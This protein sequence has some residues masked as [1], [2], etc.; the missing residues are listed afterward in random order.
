MAVPSGQQQQVVDANRTKRTRANHEPG[1]YD[2]PSFYSSDY[3][4]RTEIPIETGADPSGRT[5]DA[6]FSTTT[7]DGPSKED[8]ESGGRQATD[9]SNNAGLYR[10]KCVSFLALVAGLAAF[11]CSLAALAGTTNWVDTWEPIDLPPTQDWPL[12]FGTGYGSLI[13]SRSKTST[14]S[15]SSSSLTTKATASGFATSR[16]DLAAA[17]SNWERLPIHAMENVT[18][19]PSLSAGTSRPTTTVAPT[20]PPP[21]EEDDEFDYDDDD[22][23]YAQDEGRQPMDDQVVMLRHEEQDEDD[24]QVGADGQQQMR[25]TLIVVFHVGLFRACPVLKGELPSSVVL[26]NLPCAP[27]EYTNWRPLTG[28]SFRLWRNVEYTPDFLNKLRYATPCFMLG[29]FLGLVAVIIAIGGRCTGPD[30]TLICSSLHILA[31]LS[32][33]SGLIIF[34]SVLHEEFSLPSL[35]SSRHSGG[36]PSVSSSQRFYNGDAA[37]G[38]A[39][40]SALYSDSRSLLTA[41]IATPTGQQQ[42]AASSGLVSAALVPSFRYGWSFYAALAAFVSSEL[43]AA[44]YIILH[45][46]IFKWASR[47]RAAAEAAAI[48]SAKLLMTTNT[49]PSSCG[50]SSSKEIGIQTSP[51]SSASLL[52]MMEKRSIEAPSPTSSAIADVT[53]HHN[54]QMHV[55]YCDLLTMGHGRPVLHEE[56]D[57]D[58]DI[59]PFLAAGAGNRPSPMYINNTECDTSTQQGRDCTCQIHY[60]T[61]HRPKMREASKHI[62]GIHRASTMPRKVA[63][64]GDLTSVY[65]Q[66][67]L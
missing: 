30:R 28:L 15:K 55:P 27:L 43:A 33:G 3:V 21:V 26:P 7:T 13:P 4:A 59:P 51:L 17:K 45:T 57:R 19:S 61:C 48:S 35:R 41:T 47:T 16:P 50:S 31:G 54:Q 65:Q 34:V 56:F 8:S 23:Y 1:L 36:W 24:E 14:Q 52:M 66:T 64:A 18:L 42:S 38:P 2:L 25:R 22:D 10:N 46:H 29:T 67:P 12:L 6:S 63:F 11:G 49:G 39:A 37:V 53:H 5:N 9:S 32:L 62:A 60:A 20:R 58:P 40:G 44:V